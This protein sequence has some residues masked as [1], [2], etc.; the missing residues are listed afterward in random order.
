M[1]CFEEREDIENKIKATFKEDDE[2]MLKPHTGLDH[3]VMTKNL[4]LRKKYFKRLAELN[5]ICEKEGKKHPELVKP[6]Q[7]F[8][9]S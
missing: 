3:P 4:L 1:N 2:T 9:T 8:A 7:S 5:K 6:K